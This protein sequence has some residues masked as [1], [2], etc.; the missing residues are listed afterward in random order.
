MAIK[1]YNHL[2]FTEKSKGENNLKNASFWS[3]LDILKKANASVNIVITETLEEKW[4]FIYPILHFECDNPEVL[5]KALA[6]YNEYWYA[7]RLELY[8][9][10]SH[11]TLEDILKEE[12]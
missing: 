6:I 3:A 10:F 7:I 2:Y 1:K 9:D 11:L 12:C 5:K 8:P 4:T